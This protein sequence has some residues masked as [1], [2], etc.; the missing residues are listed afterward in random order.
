MKTWSSL[1]YQQCF[2]LYNKRSNPKGWITRTVKWISWDWFHAIQV[3]KCAGNES[4]W[5]IVGVW[6][7]F[8]WLK[9]NC[10]VI[11]DKS[12]GKAV[13]LSRQIPSLE[14]KVPYV[15]PLSFTCWYNADTTIHLS[16]PQFATNLPN[17]AIWNRLIK[18]TV[19]AKNYYT[20]ILLCSYK[21]CSQ[22]P[23]KLWEVMGSLIN[24]LWLLR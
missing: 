9:A 7:S 12:R 8:F 5:L 10:Y 13:L 14:L 20:V 2:R 11:W 16:L 17:K 23:S 21:F 1:S 22:S 3:K 19:R 18:N 4:W 6:P 15:P 24:V